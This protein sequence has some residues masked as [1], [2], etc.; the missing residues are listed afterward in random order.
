MAAVEIAG[1]IQST[2]T[3]ALMTPVS[4]FNQEGN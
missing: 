4:G 3:I 2:D 1:G